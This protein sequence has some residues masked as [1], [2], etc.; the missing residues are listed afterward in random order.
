[1]KRH[2]KN[3][4][5]LTASDATLLGGMTCNCPDDKTTKDSGLC[6][7]HGRKKGD[8]LARGVVCNGASEACR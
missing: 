6:P 4:E 1:M 7:M 2:T 8:P 3:C 5:L